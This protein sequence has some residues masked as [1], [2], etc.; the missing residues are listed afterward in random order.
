MLQK[1]RYV[2]DTD[3][4]NISVHEIQKQWCKDEKECR[5]TKGVQDVLGKMK[6]EKDGNEE[7]GIT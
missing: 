3:A 2:E 7:G 4:V 5:Y 1:L 6:W